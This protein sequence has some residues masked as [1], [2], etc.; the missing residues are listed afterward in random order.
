MDAVGGADVARFC[1]HM[2]IN[3]LAELPASRWVKRSVA[4]EAKGAASELR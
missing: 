2:K 4:L 3:S 1:K